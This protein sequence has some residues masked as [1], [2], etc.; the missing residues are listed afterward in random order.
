LDPRVQRN[1]DRIRAAAGDDMAAADEAI[2]R[3][4]HQIEGI[5]PPRPLPG[6]ASES[7]AFTGRTPEEAAARSGDYNLGAQMARQAGQGA[8]MGFEEE[9]EAGL[10]APFSPRTYPDI[11]DELRAKESAFRKDYPVTAF[12]SE[13]AGALGSGLAMGG[14]SLAKAGAQSLG[15]RVAAGAGLGAAQGAVT[16][17]GSA[18]GDM[19]DRLKGA[20]IGGIAGGVFGGALPLG[21][22]GVRVGARMLREPTGQR[23]ARVADEKLLEAITRDRKTPASM[24]ERV[25]ELGDSPVTRQVTV[26]DAGGDNVHGLARAVQTTPGPGKTHVG[27]FLDTRD[28]GQAQRYAGAVSARG[29]VNRENLVALAEG[30]K[31]AR[32]LEAQ[33]MY[34]EAFAKAARELDDDELNAL[35]QNYPSFREAWPKA[36]RLM[37]EAEGNAAFNARTRGVGEF[38]GESTAEDVAKKN[39]RGLYN[40]ARTPNGTGFRRADQV[41]EEGIVAELK[42]LYKRRD[43]RMVDTNYETVV[44]DYGNARQVS[45]STDAV[46]SQG[47]ARTNVKQWD[48]IIANYE[49]ELAKRGWSQTKIAEAVHGQG[50]DDLEAALERAAMEAQDEGTAAG[51]DSWMWDTSAPVPDAP[52]TPKRK[53]TPRELHYLKMA[54]DERIEGAASANPLTNT[55]A[56]NTSAHLMGANRDKLVGRMNE[57]IPGYEEA[58]SNFAARSRG[59]EAVTAGERAWGKNPDIIKAEMAA[60]DPEARDLY[61]RSLANAVLHDIRQHSTSPNV[62]LRVFGSRGK[63]AGSEDILEQLRQAMPDETQFRLLVRD[64]EAEATL[65]ETSRSVGRGSRTAPA[66]AE[67]GD[68]ASHPATQAAQQLASG[69]PIRA[70]MTGVFAG[71]KRRAQGFSEDV[72]RELAQRLT[73][74]PG[75]DPE[76]FAAMLYALERSGA[77]RGTALR[78]ER[79][80]AGFLG[81][82]S[83]ATQGQ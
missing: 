54:M 1:I 83:G 59:M 71:A 80:A 70:A 49:D 22:E 63:V 42:S 26:M 10:R 36:V 81:N 15:R 44:D 37:R 65:A 20:A 12:A 77:R 38:P 17:A 45:R 67:Q 66:L 79:A 2:A 24:L 51:D 40:D 9:L 14:A 60:L 74:T 57:L 18:N 55:G 23:A 52:A 3:Y 43:A 82:R 50:G 8:L 64:L 47:K 7:T 53:P 39:A 6:F 72:S 46:T 61:R 56:G 13:A 69:R 5:A 19:G 32:T 27:D 62:G 75:A 31:N 11:R 30:L 25:D 33:K 34:G 78:G 73:A 21:V 28:A 41:S 29:K 76:A 58:S 48:T 68:L 35:L 4:L 16:G